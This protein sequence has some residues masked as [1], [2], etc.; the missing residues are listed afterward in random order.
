MIAKVSDLYVKSIIKLYQH[1]VLQLI[2]NSK[3]NAKKLHFF[4]SAIATCLKL[5]SYIVN[6]NLTIAA[7]KIKAKNIPKKAE[8][9]RGAPLQYYRLYFFIQRNRSN[10]H[11]AHH[12]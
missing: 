10:T 1:S 8:A 11:N 2:A 9:H 6:G 4:C 12:A 7:F 5:R 3:K